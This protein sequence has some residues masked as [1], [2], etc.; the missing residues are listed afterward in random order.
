MNILGLNLGHDSSCTLIV[1]SK[2]I[3][4]CEEERYTKVKHSRAFPINAI[5]D[6][7]KIGKITIHDVDIISVGFLPKK[8]VQE[9]YFNQILNDPKKLSL[10]KDGFSRIVENL[11]L[12]NIIRKKLN[13][14]KKIEFNN[15]HFCH[16]ASAFYPSGFNK[17][18]I[19]S[20][21]G[22]GEFE[23]GMIGIGNHNKIKV[24]SDANKFP[25]SMGLIYA[26]ITNYLGW[27]SFYDEGIVMGLAPYGDPTKIIAKSKKSYINIFREIIKKTGPITYEINKDWI[28]YHIERNTWLSKKFYDIF[29]KKR[30]EKSQITSH[31]KNIAAALQCRLEEI[32]IDQLKYL[33]NKYKLDYICIAGGVGLNCSLNGK[34]HD[35]GIFKKIFIKPASGDAGVSYGAALV[36]YFKKPNRKNDFKNKDFYLGSRFTNNEIKKILEKYNKKLK[37]K[38]HKDI[39]KAAAEIISKKKNFRMVSR[40]S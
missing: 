8:Y 38:L 31:H 19:M 24:I 29:G 5:H 35:S 16:L 33:K 22:I 27:Q 21:D 12:E 32:I 20:L 9:F 36:E 18:L 13:F 37:F 26:A 15:H 2:I 14:K 4:A 10:F 23:T 6:C 7:L 40:W 30:K 3:A 17:S 25:N 28:T 11:D 1:K 39:S 34:I